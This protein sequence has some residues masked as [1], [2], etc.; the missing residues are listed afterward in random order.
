MA[1]ISLNAQK[2]E[3][4]TKGALN[5]MRKSGFVPG[6][7]YC[8]GQEPIEFS[9][10]EVE[11]NPFVFTSDT[12]I[13]D[14]KVGNDEP[15]KAI[16]KDIQFDPVTDRVV[17]IDMHGVTFG[18]LMEFQVPVHLHGTAPGVKAGGTLATYLHKLDIECMP[19][20]I[21]DSLDI[22]I[23]GLEIGDS[24][25]VRDLEYENVKILNPQ[26]A[27]VVGVVSARGIE[28]EEAEAD[29]LEGDELTEPEVIGKGKSEEETED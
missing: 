18:Q 23:D 21:P 4:T 26:D 8:K 15:L 9:V 16:I 29:E 19:K 3:V 17:H 20:N 6:V 2:R 1:E 13:I 28:E 22:T 5:Q 7:Y 10:A 14:L 27:A 11:L 24:I 12:H 25:R